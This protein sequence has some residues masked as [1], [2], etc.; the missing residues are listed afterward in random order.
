MIGCCAPRAKIPQRKTGLLNAIVIEKWMPSVVQ[1]G[2]CRLVA[3]LLIAASA[4]AFPAKAQVVVMGTQQIQPQLDSNP[5]GQ[6]EAF[7][8]TAVASGTVASISV[9]LDSGS[10]PNQLVVGLYTDVT[11][12][13]GAL[14][15]Q[16]SVNAPTAGAWNIVTVPSVQVTAGASYW[17]AILSPAKAGTMKFRDKAGGGSSQTS[18]SKT[19][20]TL[21]TVWA[22]GTVY[23]DGA[24]SAYAT[25]S[26]SIQPILSVLPASLSF[27]YTQGGTVPV[28]GLLSITNTGTGTLSFTASTNANWLSASPGSGTAPLTEQITTAVSGLAVGTYTGQITVTAPG[29][30]SSP[31]T[32]PV[33]LVVSAPVNQPVLAVTPT[34][35]SFNYTLGMPPLSPASLT[36]GNT[37]GGTLTFTASSNSSWLSVTP[38]AGTATQVE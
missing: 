12:K 27:A 35:L 34:S 30:Q 24:L 25:A 3:T 31:A 20:T 32:I 10:V 4:A 26:G 19:L 22:T 21:P 36:V 11:G 37:G 16:G 7:K 15:T 29:A 13:P 9:Y 17:F 38:T 5:A 33:T 14:L 28:P 8:T 23:S 6:A 2:I 1:R 18:A